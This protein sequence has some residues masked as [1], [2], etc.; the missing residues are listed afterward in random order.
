M[1]DWSV[2]GSQAVKEAGGLE[3]TGVE[4]G[5]QIGQLVF[6]GQKD[7]KP[8][9]ILRSAL[10]GPVTSTAASVLFLKR[11]GSMF[12]RNM[13]SMSLNPVFLTETD[14]RAESNSFTR[15][16]GKDT[17]TKPACLTLKNRK[18]EGWSCEKETN[19]R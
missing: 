17:V 13:V 2:T 14:K 10:T 3:E 7:I 15:T 16:G 5:T 11:N 1:G 19:E 18:A 4:S 8:N 9:R 12:Y 6:S